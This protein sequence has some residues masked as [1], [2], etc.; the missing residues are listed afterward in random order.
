MVRR[1]VVAALLCLAVF[2][3]KP[4]LAARFDFIYVDEISLTLELSDWSVTAFSDFGLIVNKGT[5]VLDAAAMA[6]AEF[7]VDGLPVWPDPTPWPNPSF[8]P[9]FNMFFF[10]PMLPNQAV[11]PI[12]PLGAVIPPLLAPGETFLD[13]APGQFV[14]FFLG[15]THPPSGRYRFDAHLRI[16]DE[17]AHFPVFLNLTVGAPTSLLFTH[18]ARVSSA[19]LVTASR[20]TSWGRLKRL[21]RE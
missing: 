9:Q 5:S 13:T 15:G 4:T 16:G 19:P 6:D 3:P 18:A 8:N 20:T 14:F 12:G 21:Y 1:I 7:R 2:S 10:Q 11:G 17:E